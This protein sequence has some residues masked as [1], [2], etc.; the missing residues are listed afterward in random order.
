[1]A[2]FRSYAAELI[3]QALEATAVQF[4]KF[5][6]R[7]RGRRSKDAQSITVRTRALMRGSANYPDGEVDRGT[8]VLKTLSSGPPSAI[9][10]R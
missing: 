7:V 6:M 9:P 4:R 8:A 1:V 3:R 5:T 10:A 2:A